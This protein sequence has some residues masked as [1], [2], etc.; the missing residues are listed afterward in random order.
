MSAELVFCLPEKLADRLYP[1]PPHP[2][3]GRAGAVRCCLSGQW[4]IFVKPDDFV[5]QPPPRR[6]RF[7]VTYISFPSLTTPSRHKRPLLL[8]DIIFIHQGNDRLGAQEGLP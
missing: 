1:Q 8:A 2:N 6:L 4:L 3:G 5:L 7:F